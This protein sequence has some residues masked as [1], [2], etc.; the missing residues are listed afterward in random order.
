MNEPR[1]LVIEDDPAIRRLLAKSLTAA[2]FEIQSADDG[3]EGLERAEQWR[4]DLVVLDLMMPRVDGWQVVS[5]LRANPEFA[6]TPILLLTAANTAE[7]RYAAF[8]L[9]ADD[10]ISKPFR[11][12]EIVIRVQRALRH[13]A[14]L[15]YFAQGLRRMARSEPP[16][17]IEP[18]ESL[19]PPAP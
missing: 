3:A 16:L 15:T 9:G 14:Q 5:K 2:G 17:E 8:K 10:Y 18:L 1:I 6:L 12:A 11:P 19:P 7:D 13:R 4:P